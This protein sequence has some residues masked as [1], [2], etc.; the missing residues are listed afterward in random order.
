MTTIKTYYQLKIHTYDGEKIFDF[1]FRS[2]AITVAE[3]YESYEL[4]ECLIRDSKGMYS[5]YDEQ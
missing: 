4:C 1:N 5:V 2:D 3:N